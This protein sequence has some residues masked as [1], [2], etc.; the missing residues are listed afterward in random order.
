MVCKISQSMLIHVYL[1]RVHIENLCCVGAG[2]CN[3]ATSIHLARHLQELKQSDNISS[4][5]LLIQS[6][7]ILLTIQHVLNCKYKKSKLQEM[8]TLAKSSAMSEG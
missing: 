7:P 2:D 3:E 5:Q 6:I 1:A 8:Q 4:N